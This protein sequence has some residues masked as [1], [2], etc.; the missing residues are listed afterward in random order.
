MWEEKI[1]SNPQVL[2]GKPTI[3]G[4][5]LSVEFILSLL[6]QGWSVAETIHNYP[7]ITEADVEAC[8]RFAK[9]KGV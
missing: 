7:R 3:K 6:E 1:E 5:R 8:R 2:A 9:T 4:T